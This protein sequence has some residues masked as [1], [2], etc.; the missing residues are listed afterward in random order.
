MWFDEIP[1]T[2]VRQ[3]GLFALRASISE[4]FWIGT[5]RLRI[6]FPHVPTWW[7][8]ALGVS[9]NMIH[10]PKWLDTAN[11]VW[12]SELAPGVIAI[13]V[14]V[15]SSITMKIRQPCGSILCDLWDGHGTKVVSTDH[16]QTGRGCDAWI[17]RPQ[18]TNAK[19]TPLALPVVRRMPI[20][21][22]SARLRTEHSCLCWLCVIWIWKA[23]RPLRRNRCP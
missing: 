17:P 19:R 22:C 9:L 5:E 1:L 16:W 20:R 2:A 21:A 4:C 3:T 18:W 14:I 6:P 7:N 11:V 23:D 15:F 8:S 13:L 12:V 10:P